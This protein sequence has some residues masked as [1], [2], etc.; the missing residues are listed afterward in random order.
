MHLLKTFPSHN[1]GY[2]AFAHNR[3]LKKVVPVILGISASAA[4]F[5][6]FIFKLADIL[7]YIMLKGRIHAK[8]KMFY[9]T[10]NFP[11][12]VRKQENF[13]LFSSKNSAQFMEYSSTFSYFIFVVYKNSNFSWLLCFV[14]AKKREL[15]SD[16]LIIV[17]VAPSFFAANV[18]IIKNIN[19]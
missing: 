5:Y 6:L 17:F 16:I 8:I 19:E 1:S 2:T 9:R 12:C 10:Q 7:W 4:V 11:K 3:K 13:Y 15:F 18:Y 14:H